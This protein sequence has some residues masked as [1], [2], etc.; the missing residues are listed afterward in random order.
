MRERPH[1][2]CCQRAV[3][4]RGRHAVRPRNSSARRTIARRRSPSTAIRVRCSAAGL[5]SHA[6]LAC[7]AA[8]IPP[9]LPPSL[10]APL[11]LCTLQQHHHLQPPTHTHQD[12]SAAIENFVS[13][14]GQNSLLGWAGEEEVGSRWKRTRR[15]QRT[16]SGSKYSSRY[17]LGL[18]GVG[19]RQSS[20][21]SRSSSSSLPI[22]FRLSKRSNQSRQGHTQE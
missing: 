5:A 12:V 22:L 15:R 8:G 11:P 14:N 9:S 20:S 21:S 13:K 19:S 17:L 4:A 16:I 18:T 10:P 7:T 1:V 6:A 3:Q 2:A